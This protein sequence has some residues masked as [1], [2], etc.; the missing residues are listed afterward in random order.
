MIPV[1]PSLHVLPLL[2][3]VLSHSGLDGNERKQ[4]ITTVM[5]TECIVLITSMLHLLSL[6]GGNHKQLCAH[7]SPHGADTSRLHSAFMEFEN[8]QIMQMAQQ[9][10]DTSCK[11]ATSQFL[12]KQKVV[13]SKEKNKDK[14]I[15]KTLKLKSEY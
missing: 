8:K 14:K 12:C 15:N 7:A 2:L 4:P 10:A 3:F 6:H 1:C 11:A 9:C 5:E 13:C